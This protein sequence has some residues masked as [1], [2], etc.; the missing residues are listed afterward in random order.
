MQNARLE[1][2]PEWIGEERS[3]LNRALKRP[4]AN[5][6]VLSRKHQIVGRARRWIS[7]NE[8]TL[9]CVIKTNSNM[10]NSLIIGD[11]FLFLYIALYR[12]FFLYDSPTL[13]LS[14]YFSMCLCTSHYLFLSLSLVLFEILPRGNLT[15]TSPSLIHFPLTY[16]RP[17]SLSLFA[18]TLIIIQT[19]VILSLQNYFKI[20]F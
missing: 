14:L 12:F 4:L 3:L 5:E 19:W 20:D 16:T 8:N 15:L 13:N 9:Q 7:M 2:R 10:N 1:F 17:L 11:S 6:N 18:S